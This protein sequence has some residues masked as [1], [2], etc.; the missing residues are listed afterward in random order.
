MIS[1]FDDDSPVRD[2]DIETACLNYTAHKTE[3]LR[4]KGICLHGWI[5]TRACT[6]LDCGKTWRNESAMMEEINDLREQFL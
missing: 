2:A 6:C 5:D 4:K 3:A 1:S